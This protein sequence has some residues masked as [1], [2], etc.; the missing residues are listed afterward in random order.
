MMAWLP[1]FFLFYNKNLGFKDIIILESV[2]YFAVVV[3]E[4]PSGYF[5]DRL[6]RKITLIIS[7][8]SFTVAYFIFGIVTPS[9]AS[10]ALAQVLF[11]CGYS[12]MSGTDTSF[13]YESLQE[14]GLEKEYPEREARVQSWAGYAGAIA[15]L[16]GG[17]LG[18]IQLHYG[19]LIS[20][21]FMLPALLI[22]FKFSETK[23]ES[24]KPKT[25]IKQANAIWN[26]TKLPELR[27]L[28]FYSI[29]IYVL[30]HIPYEFYQPYLS[31]LEEGDFS[32]PFGA[33]MYSGILFA[34][35]RFFGAI[36][37]GQS[38][39]LAKI[40]GLRNLCYIAIIMQLLIIGT[41]GYLLHSWIILLIFLRS[42]SMSLTTAPINA[43]IAPRI[44]KSHRA[45]YFSFQSLVSRLSFSITLILL[46][47]PVSHQVI[48][49]WPTLSTMFNY[50]LYGGLIISFPLLFLSSGTLFGKQQN[51]T[52]S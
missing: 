18:S 49:D 48:N 13:Y 25:A 7:S 29:I 24:D 11:A 43:A 27:W 9:F 23:T 28:F 6:G 51:T 39:K 46:A 44:H 35:T 20:L 17:Y 37:S 36:A 3:L 5:S 31:L 22:T 33:A 41:L 32:M 21:I 10:F 47:I 14:D 2:Y 19:Y 15:A 1:I 45:T 4:V 8:I 42:V 30:I 38:I 50:S 12:F 52:N 40:F 26:Y 34:G 16:L